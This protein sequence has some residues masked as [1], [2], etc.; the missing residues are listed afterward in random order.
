MAIEVAGKAIEDLGPSVEHVDQCIGDRRYE[1]QPGDTVH[2]KRPEGRSS[3]SVL[4]VPLVEL[5]TAAIRCGASA[6]P[7]PRS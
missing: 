4:H 1:R 2:M 5:E 3:H 6:Q 7:E